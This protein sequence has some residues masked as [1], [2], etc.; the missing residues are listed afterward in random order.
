MRAFTGPEGSQHR[1]RQKAAAQVPVTGKRWKFCPGI[2]VTRVLKIYFFFHHHIQG[3][4]LLGEC[5]WLC[6]LPLTVLEVR[7]RIRSELACE[8]T[9]GEGIPRQ[10]SR[11]YSKILLLSADATHGEG[12][13]SPLQCSCLENPTDRG[14]LRAVVC[15]VTQ[16]QTRLSTDP[17][18]CYTFVCVLSRVWLS[19]IP[20]VHGTFQARTLEG[21]AISYFRGSSQPRAGT[22]VSCISCIAGGFFTSEPPEKPNATYTRCLINICWIQ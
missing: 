2:A 8:L 14:A 22:H 12:N 13:G 17:S 5:V 21:V 1:N 16:S 4:I 19:A 20:S 3:S 6:K 11:Y 15:G 10:E 18:G 7:R 9:L